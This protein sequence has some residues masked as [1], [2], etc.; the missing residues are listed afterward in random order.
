MRVTVAR[1]EVTTGSLYYCESQNL[2]I[3]MTERQTLRPFSCAPPCLQGGESLSV[4]R[5]QLEELYLAH[6]ASM[7]IL[8]EE[9]EEEDGVHSDNL[10]LPQGPANFTLLWYASPFRFCAVVWTSCGNNTVVHSVLREVSL[11]QQITNVTVVF[12]RFSSGTREKVLRWLFPKAELCPLLDSAGTIVQRCLVTHST[13]S[14]SKV[15][16]PRSPSLNQQ[17]FLWRLL[18]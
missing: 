8:L 3:E 4:Q 15:R 1:W 17:T 6:S 13:N 7:T 2:A 14:Q 10:R 16:S 9:E 18:L 11:I 12:R 5:Q